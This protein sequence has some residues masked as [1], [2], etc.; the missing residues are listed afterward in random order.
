MPGLSAPNFSAPTP[1]GIERPQ[2]VMK[3]IAAKNTLKAPNFLALVE[4]N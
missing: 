1:L 2:Q 4:A 3:P